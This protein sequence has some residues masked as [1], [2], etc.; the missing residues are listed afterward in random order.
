MLIQ[1]VGA[2]PAR[3]SLPIVFSRQNRADDKGGYLVAFG[4]LE[5]RHYTVLADLMYGQREA[6]S[7]WLE[8]RRKHMDIVRGTALMMKWGVIGPWRALSYAFKPRAVTEDTNAPATPPSIEH[9]DEPA[10]VHASR[11]SDPASIL[12]AR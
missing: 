1:P 7:K 5:P 2:M 4:A 8:S 9:R 6:L 10:R 12:T 11:V 3:D